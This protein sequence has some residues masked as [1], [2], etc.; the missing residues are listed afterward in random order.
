MRESYS[1][2]GELLI[3][4]ATY[5]VNMNNY[6]LYIAIVVDNNGCSQICSI[7]LLSHEKEP[8]FNSYLEHFSKRND[9]SKTTVILS[10][11]DMVESHGFEQYF[12]NAHHLLCTWHVMKNF[13]T[14]FKSNYYY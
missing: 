12:P 1:L 5:C 7:A 3:I 14:H 6:S 8:V 4:D 11:K 13:K 10:D 9:I 2:F